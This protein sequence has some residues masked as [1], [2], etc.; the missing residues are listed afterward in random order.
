M[1]EDHAMIFDIHRMMLDDD[2]YLE[3]IEQTVKEGTNAEYAVEMA[4]NQ[5]TQLFA[6][7]DDEYMKARAVDIKDISQR[8]IRIRVGDTGGRST[9]R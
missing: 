4:Q 8:V 5:F 2:D 9:D 6:S 7:M 3:A 1:G